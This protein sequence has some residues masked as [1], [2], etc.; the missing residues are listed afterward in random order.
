[1]FAHRLVAKSMT[2]LKA[3]GG[4]ERLRVVP[5]HHDGTV[6]G[7][8]VQIERLLERKAD[9]P[10]ALVAITTPELTTTLTH[11]LHRGIQ[12]PEEMSLVSLLDDHNVPHLVPEITRYTVSMEVLVK[13]LFIKLQGV[14]RQGNPAVRPSCVMCE[15]VKGKT[16]GPAP[17]QSSRT[18]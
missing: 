6:P 10:T 5:V 11:L 8:R 9:R 7:I 1:M 12:I 2:E 3:P 17:E 14:W 16:L 4:L 15:F 13:R 18:S